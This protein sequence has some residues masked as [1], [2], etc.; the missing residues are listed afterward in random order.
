[1]MKTQKKKT[2]EG[3]ETYGKAKNKQSK[4][5]ALNC[6]PEQEEFAKKDQEE[7]FVEEG[8]R[9]QGDE[10]H[11]T[12]MKEQASK[13]RRGTETKQSQHETKEDHKGRK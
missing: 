12:K 7:M 6:T 4:R 5:T 8:E 3:K 9:V 11:A 10:Q 13:Q 1:M 2:K